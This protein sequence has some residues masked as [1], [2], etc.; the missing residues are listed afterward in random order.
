MR[1]LATLLAIVA[2]TA[3][4]QEEKEASATPHVEIKTTT[5]TVMEESVDWGYNKSEGR[6]RLGMSNAQRPGKTKVIKSSTEIRQVIDLTLQPVA[7]ECESDIDLEYYQRD[8][9]T[10][11]RTRFTSANCDDFDATY[12]L[13]ITYFDS[14]GTFKRIVAEEQWPNDVTDQHRKSYALEPNS[15]LKRISSR[16]LSCT[17]KE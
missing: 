14:E 5:K 7:L 17:C 11:V 4:A 12:Q 6:S 3:H 13:Q 15:E 10:E 9:E 8:T 1:I 2:L 16:I